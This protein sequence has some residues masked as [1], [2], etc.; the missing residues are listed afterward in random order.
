M[1]KKID[2]LR[3]KLDAFI[4]DFTITKFFMMLTVFLLIV[5]FII[6]FIFMCKLVVKFIVANYELL[7]LCGSIVVAAIYIIWCKRV[8]NETTQAVQMRY[9][10][11][12]EEEQEK[13]NYEDAYLRIQEL[14]FFVLN[15]TAIITKIPPL[16][17]ASALDAPIHFVLVNNSFYVFQYLVAKDNATTSDLFKIKLLLNE[18][19]RQALR[20]G[21][22][23]GSHEEFFS[24]SG[25]RYPKILIHDI[26]DNGTFLQIHAVIVG[27]PYADYIER[28]KV[29]RNTTVDNSDLDF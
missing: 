27:H 6:L 25:K 19:I 26:R 13:Q 14:L 16:K 1:K 23:I 17:S 4:A 22:I 5:L 28:A 10:T 20:T 9:Q 24:N 21:E 12:F 18:R 29:V 15:D 11:K 3:A 8:N 2:E 7:L